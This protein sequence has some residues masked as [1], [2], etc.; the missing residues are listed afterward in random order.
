MIGKETNTKAKV[1]LNENNPTS[2]ANE[3]KMGKT[4][5]RIL[6]SWLQEIIQK[7]GC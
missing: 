5:G 4:K 6:R 7:E 3:F 1:I 2:V